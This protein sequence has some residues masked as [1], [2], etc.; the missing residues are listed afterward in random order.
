MTTSQITEYSATEAALSELRERIGKTT[1]DVTTTTGM[2]LARKDRRELVKLR[3]SLEAKRKEIKAPALA[4]CNLIDAEAKRITLELLK[5]EEPI[6]NLIKAEE[7]RKE[8]ERA[9]KARIEAERVANIRARIDKIKGLPLLTVNFNAE[10]MEKFI[11]TVEAQAI[12]VEFEE[13]AEEATIAKA[14][15][16]DTLAKVLAGK[17]ASE[18]EAAKI[19]AEQEAE[20]AR[21]EEERQKMEAERLEREKAETEERERVRK[22]QEEEAARLS[23]EKA[24]NDRI[25]AEQ[26]EALL[27]EREAFEEERKAALSKQEEESRKV[28]EEQEAEAKRLA[29]ELAEL[30]RQREEV[31]AKQRQLEEP[32]A[33]ET[34][35]IPLAEYNRLVEDSRLLNALRA[36]GVDNW[37]GWDDAI[38]ALE[39]E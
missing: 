11:N 12:G 2:E 35:T 32:Q 30:S 9:E 24:E 4:H 31:A 28:R 7:D 8:K 38:D 19:K 33:E 37:E 26:T 29:D 25:A 5:L 3:T 14:E 20:A 36:G 10:Q 17:L 39:A 16:M 13:F 6:D 22:A 1:H 18:A 15:V 21:L 27:K 23:A 34:I